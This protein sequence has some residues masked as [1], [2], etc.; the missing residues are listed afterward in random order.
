MPVLKEEYVLPIC[1]LNVDKVF[2]AVP[3]L[4]VS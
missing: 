3:K 1:A 2:P 4:Y